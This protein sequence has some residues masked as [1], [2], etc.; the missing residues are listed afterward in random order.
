MISTKIM[1]DGR[2]T[3]PPEVRDAL[4]LAP[5]DTIIFDIA[6]RSVTISRENISEDPFH[7]FDEWAG[8]ED[9]KGYKD[10]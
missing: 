2:V 3:I 7:Q 9:N 5:G 4:R 8:D 10:F 1:P 6:G